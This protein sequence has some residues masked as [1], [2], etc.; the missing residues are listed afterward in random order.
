MRAPRA[1]RSCLEIGAA[2]LW[3][4]IAETNVSA[5]MPHRISS[6]EVGRVARQWLS[7][8]AEANPEDLSDRSCHMIKKLLTR[9]VG[10]LPESAQ[11]QIRERYWR[12][13]SR[14]LYQSLYGLLSLELS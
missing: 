6:A 4:T 7:L 14:F 9:L 12:A 3:K 2:V 1:S 10:T 5:G 13:R 8:S 11:F